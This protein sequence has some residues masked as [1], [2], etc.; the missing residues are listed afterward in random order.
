MGG[1]RKDDA[2]KDAVR[3]KSVIGSWH[4]EKWQLTL[5]LIKFVK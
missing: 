4:R 5:T 1:A 3:T 2:K